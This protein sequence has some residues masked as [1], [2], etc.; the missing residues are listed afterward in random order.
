M[1]WCAIVDISTG[2]RKAGSGSLV[3]QDNHPTP[4]DTWDCLE[5]QTRTENK[6][7]HVAQ[8]IWTEVFK[9][10]SDKHRASRPA[11]KP[12]FPIGFEEIQD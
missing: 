4:L 8:D 1:Q 7:R 6:P 11:P 10:R 3:S 9:E 2:T 5:S 12:V